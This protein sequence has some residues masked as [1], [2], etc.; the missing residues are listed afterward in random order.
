MLCIERCFAVSC[1]S[2]KQMYR[3][4]YINLHFC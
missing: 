1:F 4:L 3:T 2:E